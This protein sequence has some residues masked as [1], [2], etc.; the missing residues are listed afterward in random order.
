[1]GS[2][3]PHI[4]GSGVSNRFSLQRDTEPVVSMGVVKL[5]NTDRK[6]D[7]IVSVTELIN[8]DFGLKIGNIGRVVRNSYRV[9]RIYEH[10]KFLFPVLRDVY[11]HS[12]FKVEFAQSMKS[13]YMVKMK[14]ANK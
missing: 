1:M 3:C 10:V 8:G 7:I 14:M 2:A 13:R 4:S 9:G 12:L 5:G 6:A 11:T